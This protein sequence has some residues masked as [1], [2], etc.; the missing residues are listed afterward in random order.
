[1]LDL[2]HDKYYQL[3]DTIELI[4]YAS[5]EVYIGKKYN[6][7]FRNL[8]SKPSTEEDYTNPVHFET[9]SIQK[10]LNNNYGHLT[11]ESGEIDSDTYRNF[12]DKNQSFQNLPN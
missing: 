5:Y 3:N 6:Q 10:H 2:K 7:D 9:E 1:L 11:Y 8:T 4:D 12:D